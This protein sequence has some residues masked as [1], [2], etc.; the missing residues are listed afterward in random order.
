V[1]TGTGRSLGAFNTFYKVDDRYET[2]FDAQGVFPY[3]FIR[4]T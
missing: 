3:A 1:A 2:H 4:R